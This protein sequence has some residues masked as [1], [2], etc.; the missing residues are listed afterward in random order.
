M[1]QGNAEIVW[2]AIEAFNRQ[3]LATLFA[4]WHP[5]GEVDWS[6]AEGPLQGTYRGQGERETFY[7]E[8]FLTFEE[9]QVEAYDL[10]EAGSEVVISNTA[11]FL[12]R[13]GIEVSA[14]STIVYTIENRQIT[15]LRMFQERAE[16]LEAAGLRE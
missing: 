2:R 15:Q 1:S 12:G 3:D 10:V 7:K 9:V 4:L 16:A 6:R 13:Q 14:K 8:F 11:H 5:D